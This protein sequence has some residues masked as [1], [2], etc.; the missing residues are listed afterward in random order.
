M[1]AKGEDQVDLGG[2]LET[3]VLGNPFEIP[4][5]QL[6]KPPKKLKKTATVSS[7][8]DKKDECAQDSAA[9]GETASLALADKGRKARTLSAPQT[10]PCMPESGS[11]LGGYIGSNAMYAHSLK[12]RKVSEVHQPVQNW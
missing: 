5:P 9:S 12:K 8:I 2:F 4:T 10:A 7:M 11:S 3:Y 6:R 1:A